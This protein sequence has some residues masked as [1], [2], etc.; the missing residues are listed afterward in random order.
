MGKIS[1]LAWMRASAHLLKLEP[2]Q[3]HFEPETNVFFLTHIVK[4]L[5]LVN[6]NFHNLFRNFSPLFC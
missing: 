4:I 1:N 6:Y 2:G 5:E 3:G